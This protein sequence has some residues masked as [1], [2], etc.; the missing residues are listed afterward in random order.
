MYKKQIITLDS[1]QKEYSYGVIPVRKLNDKN[2]EFLLIQNKGTNSWSFPKGH[3]ELNENPEQTATR[4]LEEEVGIKKVDLIPHVSFSNKYEYEKDGQKI[5]KT[6]VFFV[7]FVYD[8]TV[9]IQF[10]EVE[11]YK[12]VTYDNALTILTF[13]TQKNILKEVMNRLFNQ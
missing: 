5:A 12:W 6:I 4:E 3:A 10:G 9:T 11:N 7:G 8:P 1:N 13:E 2:L